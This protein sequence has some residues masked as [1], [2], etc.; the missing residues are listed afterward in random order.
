MQSPM[1][2]KLLKG[3][4]REGERQRSALLRQDLTELRRSIDVLASLL[5][6][7][8]ELVQAGHSGE[9]LGL[10]AAE[11]QAQMRLNQTLLRNGMVSVDRF[12]NTIAAAAPGHRSV[13]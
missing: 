13:L 1:L 10:V 3:V 12:V 8:R 4:R 2:E 5:T 11:I 9:G 7:C 6:E